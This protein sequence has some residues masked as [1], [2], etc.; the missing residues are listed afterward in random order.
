MMNGDSAVA[1]SLTSGG[2]TLISNICFQCNHFIYQVE[3]RA[4]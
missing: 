4:F 1:G 2:S 3:L